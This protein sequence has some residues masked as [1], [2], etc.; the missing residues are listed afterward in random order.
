MA[1]RAA[2]TPADDLVALSDGTLSIERQ[3]RLARHMRSCLTC[4]LALL[5]M[6]DEVEHHGGRS[7]D[8]IKAVAMITDVDAQK[9]SDWLIAMFCSTGCNGEAE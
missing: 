9:M 3:F 4:K 1:R 5:I 2:L 6:L 8:G 7:M